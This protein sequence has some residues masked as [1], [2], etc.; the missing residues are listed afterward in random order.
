MKDKSLGFFWLFIFSVVSI[1]ACKQQRSFLDGIRSFTQGVTPGDG[2]TI[3]N[4]T[5]TGGTN[6]GGTNT[7]GTN[8]GGTNTGGTTGGPVAGAPTGVIAID[9][10]GT[11]APADVTLNGAYATKSTAPNTTF[12]RAIFAYSNS[13]ST[14]TQLTTAQQCAVPVTPT[15]QCIVGTVM[16]TFSLCSEDYTGF[17]SE[18]V[19]ETNNALE[20]DTLDLARAELPY[21]GYPSIT[22]CESR[23]GSNDYYTYTAD[24]DAA[25]PADYMATPQFLGLTGHEGTLDI[26]SFSPDLTSENAAAKI[27]FTLADGFFVES[28]T[29]VTGAA[30]KSFRATITADNIQIIPPVPACIPR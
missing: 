18:S 6:T 5:N 15:P 8:T 22:V 9:F 20:Y 2:D 17:C 12:Y 7:G 27:A 30:R 24:P 29:G 14:L 1:S 16:I 28:T 26:R 21:S 3:S 19:A 25:T 13:Q 23:G 11:N 4:G 10:T